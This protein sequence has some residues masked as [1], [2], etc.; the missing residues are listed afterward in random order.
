MNKYIIEATGNIIS[1]YRGGRVMKVHVDNKGYN[2]VSLHIDGIG[3]Q[4]KLVHRLVA[5]QFLPN[6]LNLPQVNHID[7]NKSNNA[8]SNLEWCTGQDNVTHSIITGLVK[9]GSAR[10]NSKLD[11]DKVKIIKQLRETGLTYTKLAKMYGVSGQT[12]SK[13]CKNQTYQ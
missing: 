13:V 9:R 3:R 4:T 8:V 5:E 11:Y 7:G 1:K 10:P 12:I 2:R 6:P